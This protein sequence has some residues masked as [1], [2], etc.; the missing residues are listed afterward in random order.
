MS[1]MTD[2]AGQTQ[3]FINHKGLLVEVDRVLQAP[4]IAATV[5][6]GLQCSGDTYP[7]D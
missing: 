3:L 2:K 6:E 7:P 4:V 1:L 5:S